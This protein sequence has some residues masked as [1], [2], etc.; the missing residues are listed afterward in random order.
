MRPY[1]ESFVVALKESAQHLVESAVVQAVPR[2]QVLVVSHKVLAFFDPTI[3]PGL[4]L[5]WGVLRV[6]R[7]VLVCF[8]LRLH[9]T[10]VVL[11][12]YCYFLAVFDLRNVGD[13][14]GFDGSPSLVILNKA[15]IFIRAFLHPGLTMV[16]VDIL[17]LIGSHG[18]LE[19][20]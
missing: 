7:L 20:D 6:F 15:W 16:L 2:F 5:L 11:K 4:W 10:E 9:P 19:V 3:T 17:A 13:R 18:R 8:L 12:I 1:V 14:S